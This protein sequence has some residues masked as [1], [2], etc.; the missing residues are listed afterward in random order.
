LKAAWYEHNGPARD[1]LAYGEL[2]KPE[3]QEGEVRVRLHASGIN[4]S[5]VN[6]RRRRPP[7]GPRVIPHSDGAGVID[8]LGKGT[9]HHEVGQRVWVWN[10]QWKRPFGTAAEFVCLPERQVVKLPECVSF[11]AGAC[12][13]IPAFT[14]MHAL[15]QHGEIAG[16]T[17]LVTGAGSAVGHYATQMAKLAGARVIGTASD[18]RSDLARAAGADFVIDYTAE[19]VSKAI[20][21]VTA[22]DG[23]HGI[24]D[25]DFSTTA[26]LLGDN[27]VKPHGSIVCYGSNAIGDIPLPFMALLLNSYTLKFFV[28]YELSVDDR[29]AALED[30]SKVLE[31]NV[32]THNIG[33]RFPLSQI[34]VAHEAVESGKVAGNVVLE[35]G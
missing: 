19:D 4:P 15:R 16:K 3:P 32:L 24:I 11:L 21:D 9:M 20:L 23:V 17:L 18:V 22:G 8:A 2:E 27:V 30:L 35:M 1:V 29:L 26:P 33:Q 7:I 25:L 6:G 10:A 34:A 14:A 5:D 31:Q 12:L 28:V 13:G